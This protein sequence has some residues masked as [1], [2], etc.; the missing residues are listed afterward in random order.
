MAALG[1]AVGNPAVRQ[2]FTADTGHLDALEGRYVVTTHGLN[3][4]LPGGR[5]FEQELAATVSALIDAG[6]MSAASKLRE[7]HMHLG[8]PPQSP[9]L[10]LQK[11]FAALEEVTLD[12][13]QGYSCMDDEFCRGPLKSLCVPLLAEE[14]EQVPGWNDFFESLGCTVTSLREWLADPPLPGGNPSYNHAVVLVSRCR[15]FLQALARAARSL[16]LHA[17]QSPTAHKTR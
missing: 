17:M 15:L 11:A 7:A 12:L 13:C 2:R 16:Q 14:V 6:L 1:E 10:A 5:L 9:R 3:E 8:G 4:D